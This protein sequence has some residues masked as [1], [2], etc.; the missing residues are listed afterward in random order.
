[1]NSNSIQSARYDHWLKYINRRF[2]HTTENEN[3]H[4]MIQTMNLTLEEFHGWKEILDLLTINIDRSRVQHI[5]VHK[6]IIRQEKEN[7]IPPT[8]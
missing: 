4:I 6:E 2:N 1:M 7:Q 3:K 8:Q 5:V